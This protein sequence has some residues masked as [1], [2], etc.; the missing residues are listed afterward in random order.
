MSNLRTYYKYED[1]YKKFLRKTKHYSSYSELVHDAQKYEQIIIGSDQL[2][3]FQVDEKP[4]Q[5]FSLQFLSPHTKVTSYA[6]S[7]GNYRPPREHIDAFKNL[8][9]KFDE[10]SLREQDAAEYIKNTF[11]ITVEKHI[12]PVF[13]LDRNEWKKVASYSNYKLPKKPYIL[14]YELVYNP[15]LLLVLRQL[16]KET[17]LSIV[18]LTQCDNS[19]I[20]ADYTIRDAGPID[21]LYLIM[22]AEEVVST[23]FHGTAFGIIFGKKTYSLLSK[24]PSR[25]INLMKTLGIQEYAIQDETELYITYNKNWNDNEIVSIIEEER[26]KS[27]SYLS[28]QIQS[29]NNVPSLFD[30]K[31]NCCGCTACYSICPTQ[32]ITMK[33]DTEGFLYPYINVAKCV[34][35]KQCVRV[36]RFKETQSQKF[37][38]RC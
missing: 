23:S 14:C 19:D 27:L 13:L 16:K 7:M 33:A 21:F 11:N 15:K 4:N 6:V 1:F 22:N 30:K 24:N 18:L 2:W 10:V 5:Y 32:A 12:D 20:E 29:V 36:C 34:G 38:L 35:C 8:L 28:S 25:V 37:K 17:G 26:K 31:E 3:N 9:R